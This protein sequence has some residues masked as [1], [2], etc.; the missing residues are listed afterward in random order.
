ML[1]IDEGLCFNITVFSLWFNKKLNNQQKI[2]FMVYFA[3]QITMSIPGPDYG[4]GNS[5]F[6]IGGVW[7]EVVS[8]QEIKKYVECVPFVKFISLSEMCSMPN[9]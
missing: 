9:N 2:L 3:C 6:T 1:Q 8:P 4:Q 5:L 7:G